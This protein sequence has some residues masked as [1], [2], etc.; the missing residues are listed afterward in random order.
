MSSS[1]KEISKKVVRKDG[2]T[3]FIASWNVNGKVPNEIC[4]QEWL[5][6]R[7]NNKAD[8]YAIGLQELGWC[9]DFSC[10]PTQIVENW[11]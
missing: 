11:K 6:P 10:F 1:N 8:I 5:S 2:I 3:V 7:S 4:L 9:D